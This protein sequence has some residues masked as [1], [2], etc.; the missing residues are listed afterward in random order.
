LN[1]TTAR[2]V[3]AAILFGFAAIHGLAPA[4]A[5]QMKQAA[6]MTDWA[7]QVDPNNP[8]P[9]YPRPQ[10][11]RTNWQNLNGIWQFQ[12]GNT[13]EPV[14][15]NQILASE[16][17]VPFPM[18]S[19]IS[20]V[21]QYYARS[22]YRRTFTVPPAWSGQR[23]LLHL[24]AV[25]WESEPF[26]NGQS[27]GI[28]RGGYDAATYDIT[29]LLVGTGPQELIVRVYDPTDAAGEPRGKQ[30]LYPGGIMYTSVSGIWQP[31]WI[32]PV[33]ATSI[34]SLRLVPDIDNNQLSV[35]ATL[36]GPTNGITVNAVARIG[37]NLVGSISGAPGAGLLLSV[38]NATLWTP[39]NPFLYDLDITLSNGVARVDSASSYFGMRKISMATNNGFVKILLNNQFVFQ[40]GPLDQGFWPDGIYT[41]PTDLALKSDI[42]MERALGFN[43]VRKHI[44]VERA[45]WY[46]WADKLG[47][48]VWQDM[49]SAN[50]YTGNPQPL[51]VPQFEAELVRLV[52]NHW[53]S[54]GA[55]VRRLRRSPTEF[56]RRV[57]RDRFNR[58]FR[59]GT[60]SI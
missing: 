49:P 57:G 33:P 54:T 12:A 44:K 47:I 10:M 31:V 18:E 59:K 15:T 35:T 4:R 25:D 26:I 37:T 55:R 38:P 32:E 39:P 14:P 24:D 50:S 29:A 20:G 40:F 52:Q 19:A 6:L 42:E 23:I 11:V 27:A 46:Y 8:L 9:E 45:R 30:T 58:D 22:W 41:A 3:A 28:H 2:V 7:Q 53:I 48:M 21:K 13:N 43:M 17:L 1:R 51:D 36:S 5:W 16:I 34:A 56:I 60:R